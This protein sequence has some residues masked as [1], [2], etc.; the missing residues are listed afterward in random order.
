MQVRPRSSAGTLYTRSSQG[1]PFWLQENLPPPLL[2]SSSL[3]PASRLTSLFHLTAFNLLVG[4]M[5]SPPPPQPFLSSPTSADRFLLLIA[6]SG[7]RLRCFFY[8]LSFFEELFFS[9]S[10]IYV[11]FP[12]IW[13]ADS[14]DV[15]LVQTVLS[16]CCRSWSLFPPFG[17]TPQSLLSETPSSQIPL[18]N[19]PTEAL[20]TP[21]DLL[22]PP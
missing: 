20:C 3:V 16:F 10:L 9:S 1:P 18:I 11:S 5:V 4:H 6:N 14:A 8:F 19:F 17:N 7:H 2:S 12:W 22:F 15:S 21:I 13:T